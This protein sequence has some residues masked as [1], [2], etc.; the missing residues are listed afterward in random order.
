MTGML[1]TGK[2]ICLAAGGTGGHV[3]PALAV[4]ERLQ[5]EGHTT[6]LFTDG[7]GARMVTGVPQT[8]IAAA[9]PFQQGLL[10]R[11]RACLLYTSPS[12]R[13]V[14]SSRMPSSA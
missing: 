6:L 5:A 12:P 14:R 13:D 3:F 11:L 4:A 8:I 7:R 10:R 9:S 1:E 2:F